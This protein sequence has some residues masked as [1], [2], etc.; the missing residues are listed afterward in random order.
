MKNAKRPPLLLFVFLKFYL[1]LHGVGITKLP[2][3]KG[4]FHHIYRK[5]SD[6]RGIIRITTVNNN[7]LYI[8]LADRIISSKLL[9]YGYWEK[10]LT[11]LVGRIIKPGMTAI[12]IG[13]HIGYYS[14]LFSQLVQPGGKVFSFEPEPYNFSL[15]KKNIEIN[16]INN[17]IIENKAIS[18]IDNK[19][20]LYLDPDNFGGHS[21]TSRG[22][23]N[24]FIE[25]EALPLDD[26]FKDKDTHVDFIKIDIEGGEYSAL[27]GAKDII[28]KN[29]DLIMV[30]ELNPEQ[31]NVSK[32]SPGS[33][34]K[35]IRSHGFQI[36]IVDH[37]S[38]NLNK[39]EN[40]QDIIDA[41]TNGLV[42]LLCSRNKIL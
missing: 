29:P 18:D 5:I 11:D 7:K 39:L 32:I 14:V 41:C 37:K 19:L 33:F 42:N 24:N 13:A 30:L 38:G 22:N 40:D 28:R 25:V 4:L 10:G 6:K 23:P 1:F 15:L 34:L 21:A 26:Y 36:S 27:D 17:C 12:D 20:K 3:V 31:M 8:D 35:K 9:Q 2:K 16:K